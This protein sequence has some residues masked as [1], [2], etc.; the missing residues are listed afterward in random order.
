MLAVGVDI[1]EVER[2]SRGVARYG[3]RF[4][5]RFFTPLE[6]E[7]C[8]GR[9]A[10]LAGR[11]AIKEAVGKAL[12]TGIGDIAWKEV[13][14]INDERGQPHLSLHGKAARLAA[15]QGLA[16]WAISLSHTTT[17]AV[18]LAVAIQIAAAGDTTEPVHS[19]SKSDS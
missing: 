19:V 17:H 8:H 14:I 9:P 1:I 4:C 15:E 7:Q 18:G 10:S 3:A 13:E 16:E 11:F 2:V 6:Q 5:D 12:G